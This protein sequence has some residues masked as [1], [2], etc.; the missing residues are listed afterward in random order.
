M[1][2]AVLVIELPSVASGFRE[3]AGLLVWR[4]PDSGA[5]LLDGRPMTQQRAIH[6]C[7]THTR[8]MIDQSETTATQITYRTLD[9]AVCTY[10]GV[11]LDEP[12]GAIDDLE[13]ASDD[14]WSQAATRRVGGIW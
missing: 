14:P 2:A 4:S 7:L 11:D 13:M 12:R 5:L 10:E 6:A 1:S 9:G 3:S 8:N